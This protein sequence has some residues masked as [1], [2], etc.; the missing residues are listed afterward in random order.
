MAVL[1]A[2]AKF[3]LDLLQRNKARALAF[4]LSIESC[5]IPSIPA[6]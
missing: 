5:S 4:L 6:S 1:D 3:D 2:A